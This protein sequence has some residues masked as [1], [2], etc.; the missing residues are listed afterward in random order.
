MKVE[1]TMMD[2]GVGEGHGA[3]ERY[4]F[5]A[6]DDLFSHSPITVLK[7]F[8]EHVT[9]VELPGGHAG[10]EIYSALKNKERQVVTGVGLLKLP[11]GE[12]PFMVMVSPK[13]NS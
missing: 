5:E 7:T 4:E 6:P 3:D 1:A 10:Y 8:M 11:H 13:Q 12:I 2:A 9:H